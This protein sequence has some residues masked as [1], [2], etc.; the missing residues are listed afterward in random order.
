MHNA[1]A[2]ILLSKREKHALR[3]VLR[4]HN[5]G[6]AGIRAMVLLLSGSGHSSKQI[7]QTLGISERKVRDCRQRFRARGLAGLEDAP[8]PGRPK[9]IDEPF[10]QLLLTTARSNPCQFGLSIQ[11][12]SNPRLAEYLAQR[13]GIRVS[14]NWIGELLRRH[15]APR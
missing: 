5:G 2:G 13:T 11:R 6:A 8:R 14:P 9:Q 15:G 7:A 10:L 3:H 12:W 4:H 1:Q